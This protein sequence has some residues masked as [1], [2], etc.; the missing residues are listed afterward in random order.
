VKCVT[1]EKKDATKSI[2]RP[3]W[4]RLLPDSP[5][6]LIVFPDQTPGWFEEKEWRQRDG[7]GRNRKS[8]RRGKREKVEPP[9]RNPEYATDTYLA[10][11][12]VQS[13]AMSLYTS[14][15]C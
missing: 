3:A 2:W 15:A 9:L 11:F 7:K 12:F 1:F 10:A 14:M 5:R 6:E 8:G 13:Y 4:A